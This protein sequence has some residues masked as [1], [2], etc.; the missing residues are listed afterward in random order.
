MQSV[1]R[2]IGPIAVGINGGDPSFLSYSGGTIFDSEQCSDQQANHALLIVEYGQ[3]RDT[4]GTMV[5]YLL[6]VLICIYL[7]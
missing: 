7:V 4:N 6:S 5:R 1:L 2:N 3:E